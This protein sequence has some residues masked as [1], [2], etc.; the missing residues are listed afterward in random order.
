M[1]ASGSIDSVGGPRLWQVISR[2]ERKQNM[3]PNILQISN[4]KKGHLWLLVPLYSRI[5]NRVS[6][7]SPLSL[8]HLKHFIKGKPH[9]L[10]T[11]PATHI[12]RFSSHTLIFQPAHPRPCLFFSVPPPGGHFVY[13]NHTVTLRSPKM[14]SVTTYS[15]RASPPSIYE[16][17]DGCRRARANVTGKQEINF[18][19]DPLQRRHDVSFTARP[20]CAYI[21]WDGTEW[22]P[23][24]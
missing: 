8:G 22:T 21:T 23:L 6:A 19:G 5:L 7:I 12:P 13:I 3:N 16:S 14:A 2:R 15:R 24:L 1:G 10:F 9:Q 4:N 11:L 18:A 17:P 20:A